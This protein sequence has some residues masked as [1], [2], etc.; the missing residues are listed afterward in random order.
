MHRKLKK[1]A[2]VLLASAMLMQSGVQGLAGETILQAEGQTQPVAQAQAAAEGQT[3]PVVQTYAEPQAEGQAQAAAEGQT[4][5]PTEA[6]TQ[7]PTEAQTQAP[8]EAPTEAQTQA[9]TEAQTQAPTEAQTQA[10]TEAQTQAPTEAQTQASTEGQT[11]AQSQAATETEKQT[12]KATEKETEETET[13][14]SDRVNDGKKKRASD[15]EASLKAALPYLFAAES[16]DA[17]EELLE[18]QNLAKGEEGRA[19]AG[20]LT[21]FSRELANAVSSSDV[22]IINLYADKNGKLDT[23]QLDQ[24]YKNHVIDVTKKYYV[25]N[26]IADRADQPLSFSGYEMTLSGAAVSYT[27]ETQPGDILY[28]FAALDGDT[29]KDY[30]GALTLTGKLQGT[31]LAPAADVTVGSDLAGA[32]YAAKIKVGDAVEKLLQITFIKGS[33]GRTEEEAP[34]EA[35]TSEEGKSEGQTEEETPVKAETS[36]E[37]KSEGQTEEETPVK[38]E[39]SEEGKTEGQTEEEAPA[40]AETSEEGK[41]EG[42]TDEKTENETTEEP[43]SEGETEAET[44]EEPISESETEL[45]TEVEEALIDDALYMA[46]AALF[47]AED[48]QETGSALLTVTKPGEAEGAMVPVTSA[49]FVVKDAA[50]GA[51]MKDAAGLPLYDI[52]YAGTELKIE[53]LPV[54]SYLL[55]QLS[56]EDG[57]QIA[58][59]TPFVIEANSEKKIEIKNEKTAGVH[60]VTAYAQAFCNGV[61]LTAEPEQKTKHYAALFTKASVSGGAGTEG[62]AGAAATTG[63]AGTT[64]GTATTGGAGA[65]DVTAAAAHAADETAAGEAFVRVSPVRELVFDAN[66]KDS[67]KVTFAGMAAGTY[68]LVATDAYGELLQESTYQAADL[69][70]AA[71]PD[72]ITFAEDEAAGMKEL[73]LQ[74]LYAENEKEHTYPDGDFSYMA[75]LQLTKKLFAADGS[76]MKGQA[77]DVFHVDL[78]SD[79][80]RTQKVTAVPVTFDMNGKTELTQT[81]SLKL[82]A[83]RA[84]YYLSETDKNGHTDT[85]LYTPVYSPSADGKL[86]VVCGQKDVGAQTDTG[87][88]TGAAA[89][90]SNHLNDT[91]VKLR[92][93]DMDG[94]LLGGVVMAVKDSSGKLV[95]NNGKALVFKSSEKDHVLKNLLQAGQ[96]YYLSQVAAP[97]GYAPAADVAFTAER[98]AVTEVV[99]QCEKA[100]STEYSVT[101]NKQ[102]RSGGHTVYAQDDTSGSNA[103]QG[104]YTFYAALFAD[105]AHTQKVSDVRKIT[106]KGL[107]GSTTFKNLEKDTV[108]YVAETTKYGEPLES[109]GART[110]KYA[111]GGKVATTKKSRSTV[112]QNEYG[113]LPKGYRYTARLTIT[114]DVIKASG[115]N[116]KVTDTFYAGIFRRGDFSDKP[117]IVKLELKNASS[118][119]ASRRFLLPSSGEKTY[120][121]AEVNADGTRVD[122][123]TFGYSV[124]V[125][126]PT[127]KISSG[128]DA[129]VTITNQERL[130]K[131]T[132]YLTKKVYEGTSLKASNETFYAGLF[133]DAKFT[134]LYTKPIPLN[135]N[136]KS[137]LTLKLSLNLGKVADANI[138]IAEVDQNG[139]VIKNEE[140]F[141][142]EIKVVNSTAAFTQEKREV[143]TILLNSVYGTVSQ[144]DWKQILNSNGN[145]LGSGEVIS[146]NG[147]IGE[148]AQTGDDTPIGLYLGLMGAALVLIL[149]VIILKRRKRR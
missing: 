35:E 96:T 58:K 115:E 73:V 85:L 27:K 142:Y 116:A 76:A 98:G 50:T 9:T 72:G 104:R 6:Q 90:I 92:L 64:D 148:A 139:K 121:I 109:D 53:N 146:G 108:Y 14:R 61:Q 100:K 38:A 79:A 127:M 62:G 54:G 87:V 66:A 118:V 95:Y 67:R 82:T 102:V 39:T 46:D 78:Y 36:E 125:T 8:T 55:S 17:P 93:T 137:E 136:G 141:G 34:A 120:Y 16:I 45:S 30:R 128:D 80:Q 88:Q 60:I 69:S 145:Y 1:L 21:G 77:E 33:E 89:Q 70:G 41:T 133:K 12:E 107:G 81:L 112:I 132:L 110:I 57:L 59:D 113:S 22:E 23:A 68:F 31:F 42:Q 5:A 106:V 51:V 111:D 83:G 63:G 149:A 15:L 44:T 11:Q 126:T 114:K 140:Q 2:A 101:V 18:G 49:R 43:T 138:Y 131:A 129:S 25:I 103:A 147:E 37:G 84:E 123:D 32:V 40:K 24:K 134:E 4:Q 29:Y 20:G 47:S 119:Y 65:A 94:K 143:Q 28:N 91:V 124:S 122:P 52:S 74:Y 99:M 97:S 130:T 56:T 75:K 71:L 86:T 19:V 105:A 3:Q 135:M 10:P 144:D 7:A 48:V 117:T 13:E 26:V